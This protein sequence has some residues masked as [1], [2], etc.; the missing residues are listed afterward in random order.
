MLKQSIIALNLTNLQI[1]GIENYIKKETEYAIETY[2]QLLNYM[3]DWNYKDKE[4]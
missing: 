3:K 4:I 2:K 1:E